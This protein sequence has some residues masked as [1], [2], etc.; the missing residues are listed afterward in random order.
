MLK[1]VHNFFSIE[2]KD[3]I[4]F[5]MLCLMVSNF[6]MAAVKLILSLTIPSL[7]FFVNAGFSFTLAGCRFITIKR[8]KN[9]L[10]I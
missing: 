2:K 5:Y 10:F 3:R 7:W 9:M 4:V 8:Y 6:L 1:I